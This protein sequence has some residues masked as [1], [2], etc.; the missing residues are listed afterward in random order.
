MGQ[1]Y[2]DPRKPAATTLNIT[3]V[4]N[5][6]IASMPPIAAAMLG[7]RRLPILQYARAIFIIGWSGD[8]EARHAGARRCLPGL[9]A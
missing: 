2:D 5:G 3:A 9:T 8:P 4:T 7:M 6:G 1:G